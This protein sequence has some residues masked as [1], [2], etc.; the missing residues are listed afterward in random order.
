MSL[1]SG[2]QVTTTG[3]AFSRWKEKACCR[4]LRDKSE[5]ATTQS[6]GNTKA[7]ELCAPGGGNWFRDAD[8]WELYDMEADRTELNSLARSQPDRVAE[9][10]ASWNHWASRVGAVPPDE[11][12]RMR[13]R[14][15]GKR[16]Q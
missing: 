1:A 6:S 11:W 8:Q 15:S 5:R 13:S 10:R 12:Q 7:I 2:T 9:L 14:A 4:F 3:V 16:S